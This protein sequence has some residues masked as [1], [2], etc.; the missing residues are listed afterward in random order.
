[1]VSSSDLSI[2]QYFFDAQP[3]HIHFRHVDEDG[4]NPCLFDEDF[5]PAVST[6]LNRVCSITAVFDC[7][8]SRHWYHWLTEVV[9][10]WGGTNALLSFLKSEES[11]CMEG[12]AVVELGTGLGLVGICAAIRGCHVLMTDV[13]SVTK[14]TNQN[15]LANRQTP[16]TAHDA[17]VSPWHHAQCVGRGS[18]ACM[19]L[20]WL[21]DA[22]VQAASSGQDLSKVSFILACE[23]IWL[24]ELLQPYVKTLAILLHGPSRPICYMS[25]TARGTEQSTVFTAEMHVRQALSAAS[26]TAS[27]LPAFA[28]IT[29]DG[30]PVVLWK[31]EAAG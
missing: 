8:E 19:E 22:H 15:I 3:V 31:V 12:H 23:V 5:S 18:A 26:C 20:D 7:M 29:P 14:L 24:Q 6:G 4:V 10:V 30:E 2:Q 25:Y 27:A 9:Q 17:A 13:S 21:K 16:Q 1:M 28:S 11:A